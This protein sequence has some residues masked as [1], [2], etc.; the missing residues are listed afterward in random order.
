MQHL[1]SSHE[2][3]NNMIPEKIM[4]Q[5]ATTRKLRL[6]NIYNTTEYRFDYNSNTLYIPITETNFFGMFKFLDRI[7][8]IELS[9]DNYIEKADSMF[10]SCEALKR[11]IFTKPLDLRGAS[12]L[13]GLFLNCKSL[14]YIDLSNIITS[15]L[16]NDISNMFCSCSSLKEV[17]FGNNFHSE[18]IINMDNLFHNCINLEK[19]NWTDL[20]Q[21]TSVLCMANTFSNC[22][23]LMQLDLRS[24][25]FDHIKDTTNMFSN[26]NPNL[27]VL[28]NN[29]FSEE[30]LL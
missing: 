23:R 15:N 28:V 1:F 19:I 16:L 7:E 5:V 18:N 4:G 10:Y 8:Q 14:A 24:F 12:N 22:K 30:I 13:F 27:E 6:T 11:I 21:F 3:V 9:L 20:H 29:S 26:T 25:Y 17:N 2:G